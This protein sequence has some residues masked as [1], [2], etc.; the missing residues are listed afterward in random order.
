MTGVDEPPRARLP[1]GV[2]LV[3]LQ[4]HVEGDY[5]LPASVHTPESDRNDHQ[6]DWAPEGPFQS[7]YGI[8]AFWYRRRE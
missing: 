7:L 8:W 1:L 6:L 5:E 2:A 4:L 3:D